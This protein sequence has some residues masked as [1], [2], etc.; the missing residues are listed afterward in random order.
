MSSNEKFDALIKDYL[1]DTYRFHPGLAT[2]VGVHRYDE[3]LEDYSRD[4]IRAEIDNIKGYRRTLHQ[5][6]PA[7]LDIS[8]RIDHRIVE[9]SMNA[10]LLELEELRSF[11]N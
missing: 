4:A 9:N 5:I 2:F 1:E 11:E 6:D 8:A 3:E 7:E 10:R